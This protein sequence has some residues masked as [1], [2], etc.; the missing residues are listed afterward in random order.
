MGAYMTDTLHAKSTPRDVFLYLLV[1][2]ALYAIAVSAISL[3][4]QYVNTFFPDPL[5]DYY[6][7]INDTLRRVLSVLIIVTP[8][9][10]WILHFL[11]K[12]LLAHPEKHT[13]GI[14]RWLVHLTLFISGVTI[15][16][17]LVT[18]VYNFLGG[19]LTAR[20]FLK[21]VAV[22]I[23]AAAVFAYYIWDIR[24]DAGAITKQMRILG[25]AAL[26]VIA[27][28]VIGGFFLGD[29]PKEARARRLDDRRV[30][31]LWN[32]QSAVESYWGLK[33]ELPESLEQ[34]AEFYSSIPSDP[35]S[36]IPYEYRVTSKTDYELCATFT[37]PVDAYGGIGRSYPIAEGVYVRDFS[38]HVEGRDCFERSIEHLVPEK[39]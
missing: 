2:V 16:V 15:I 14:R 30:Q 1:T 13:L 24:R 12:D 29:S 6:Y 3:L 34:A 18:L 9:Y 36:G 27:G 33:Q 25:T 28:L 19:D 39:K 5:T 21:I 22:L 31:D 38:A 17:D 37:N 23:V 7:S 8:V 10:A 26:V 35:E 32:V 20:F 4:F 11:N